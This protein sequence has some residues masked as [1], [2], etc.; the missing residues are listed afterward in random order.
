MWAFALFDEMS[1]R[2]V[3]SW[4]KLI[5]AYAK[6]GDMGSAQDLFDG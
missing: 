6:S 1:Q 3:V 5:V 4:T 2:D